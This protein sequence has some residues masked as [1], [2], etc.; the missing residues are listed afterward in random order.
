MTISRS[1]NLISIEKY[2]LVMYS[3][4]VCGVASSSLLL[5]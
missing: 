5:V 2:E 1:L 4:Y 3:S